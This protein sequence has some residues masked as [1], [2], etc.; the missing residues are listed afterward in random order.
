MPDYTSILAACLP[1]FFVIGAGYLLRRLRVL[2]AEADSSLLRVALNLLFP[3]FI[4]DNLLGKTVPGGASTIASAVGFGAGFVL[5]GLAVAFGGAR[6]IGLRAA[7]RRTFAVAVGIQNYGYIPIPILMELFDDGGPTLAVQFMHTLGVELALWTAAVALLA[8]GAGGLRGGLRSLLNAPFLTIVGCLAANAIAPGAQLPGSLDK[9]VAFL[10]PCAVPVCLLLIGA[11]VRDLLRAK[12][13]ESDLC[14]GPPRAA[15]LPHP[16]AEMGAA[17]AVRLALLPAAML[18][19]ARL[20]PLNAELTHVLIV[21]AAMPGAVF[22]ILLA[23]RYSGCPA[24]AVRVAI[25]TTAVSIF[26]IPSVIVFGLWW[27]SP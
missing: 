3:A 10:A 22:P 19:A 4:I 24:T 12:A 20:L 13:A 6:L 2:T 11:T 26:T 9:T 21:Q 8:G 15:A 1:V 18:A 25:S 17:V 16:A 23:R 27:L 5:L 7:R 14:S